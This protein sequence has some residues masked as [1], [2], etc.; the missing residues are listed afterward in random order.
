MG[1]GRQPHTG[2][3]KRRCAIYAIV[4]ALLCAAPVFSFIATASDAYLRGLPFLAF[5]AY[6]RPTAYVF[7]ALAFVCIAAGSY[8]FFSKGAAWL[9]RCSRIKPPRLLNLHFSRQSILRTAL[10]IYIFWIPVLVVLF[11]CA[12]T[13][14]D[15]IDELYQALSDPPIWYFS[16]DTVVDAS[17]IDHHPWFD[18]LLF[19]AFAW[20]GR[21][22][23]SISAGMFLYGLIQTILSAL[24]LAACLCYLERLHVPAVLRIVALAFVILFPIFPATADTMQK[25]SPFSLAFLAY[26]LMYMEAFRTHGKALTR[27]KFLIGFALAIA[28]CILTKKTGVYVVGLSTIV[29]IIALRGVRLRSLLSYALPAIVCLGVLPAILFPALNIAPGG[30]QEMFGIMYQQTIT[31]LK[32][33]PD[34]VSDEQRASIERV[35]DV[36]AALENYKPYVTDYVKHW[37]KEDADASDMRSFISTWASLGASHLGL[38]LQSIASCVSP[39]MVPSESLLININVSQDGIEYYEQH[40]AEIGG[41][42]ELDV[43][44]PP[45]TQV[46]AIALARFYLMV[47]RCIPVIS[48]LFTMGLYSTWIPLF[49]LFTALVSR[50]RRDACALAPIIASALFLLVSPTSLPRYVICMVF[51]AV[52]AIGW[53]IRCLREAR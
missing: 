46:I 24:V 8:L 51:V 6:K 4:L 32:K 21:S 42:F 23:G 45:E 22:V 14:Y 3:S 48:L 28:L 11:P 13:T 18:T 15:T 10:I 40:D 35:L 26:A 25:D 38:Y 30:S 39:M 33:D 1:S 37:A 49:A 17:I 53:A 44:S 9:S 2:I 12:T 5:F 43:E 34:S 19:G 27:K 47:L 36:D 41:S 50:R 16:T 52:P 7:A 29:L 31:V 20:L